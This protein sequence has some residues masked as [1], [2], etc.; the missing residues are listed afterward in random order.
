MKMNPGPRF[1]QQNVVRNSAAQP[2]IS[3]RQ[4]PEALVLLSFFGTAGCGIG[5]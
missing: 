1:G 4:P 2:G 3:A 5:A